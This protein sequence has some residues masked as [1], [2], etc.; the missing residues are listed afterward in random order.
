M[1]VVGF[2]LFWEF[3]DFVIVC[4]IKNREVFIC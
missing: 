2:F 1:V 4:L 3:L